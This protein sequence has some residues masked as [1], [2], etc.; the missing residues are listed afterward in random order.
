M[1]ETKP[2]RVLCITRAYGEDKGGMERLSFELISEVG[3]LPDVEASALAHKG[4]KWLAP[5]FAL[6]VIPAALAAARPVDVM[7]IGDPVLSFTGWVL[8]KITGKPVAVTVHGLDIT[9]SNAFYQA[10]LTLFFRSLD[11][12]LPISEHVDTLL[13][14]R[15]KNNEL[16]I[17]VVNPGIHDRFYDPSLTRDHLRQLLNSYSLTLDSEH[18][19]LFTSGRLVNRKGHAWFIEHV[20]PRLAEAESEGGPKILYVIAGTGLE[21][22]RIRSLAGDNVVLLGRVSENDLKVL[23]NTVD[24]FVQPNISVPGDVEGFGLVLLEAA[25]C[26]RPVIASKLEGMTDAIQDGKNGA[27]IEAGNADAWVHTLRSQLTQD[28]SVTMARDHTLERFNWRKKAQA[29]VDALTIVAT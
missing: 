1:S 10:Y 28:G 21:S 14:D 12:F 25:L 29:F 8:K 5:L 26:N 2:L 13:R 20:L 6:T 9:F 23:Y 4:P 17:E 22:E 11:L 18:K 15:I 3:K 24:V 7:H 16:S 19:V 27:L